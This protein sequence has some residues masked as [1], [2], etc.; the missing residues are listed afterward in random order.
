MRMR[1][2]AAV[3]NDNQLVVVG[4]VGDGGAVTDFVE[5]VEDWPSAKI[6]PHENFLLS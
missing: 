2:L 4:G 5:N 1:A 6:G 3:V